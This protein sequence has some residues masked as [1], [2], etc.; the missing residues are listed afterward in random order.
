MSGLDML[1]VG[2]GGSMES[3]PFESGVLLVQFKED[4]DPVL[5]STQ[6]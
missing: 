3:R 1:S 5:P 2:L 4:E 6:E